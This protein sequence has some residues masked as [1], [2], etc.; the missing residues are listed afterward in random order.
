MKLSASG[1]LSSAENLDFRCRRAQKNSGDPRCFSLF[2]A[3]I[4][5]RSRR[6][7]FI[8]DTIYFSIEMQKM[9]GKFALSHGRG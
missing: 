7:S 6:Q 2:F 1:A 5:Y 4:G 3:I 9:Q 8:I